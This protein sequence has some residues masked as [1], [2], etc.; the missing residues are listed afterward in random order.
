MLDI[1]NLMIKIKTR[2]R[3]SSQDTTYGVYLVFKF[4][5]SRKLSAKHMY[6][7]LKYTKGSETLHAYFAT[8]RDNDWMIPVLTLYWRASRHIIVE[9]VPSMLKALS[10]EQLMMQMKHEGIK[11]VLEVQQVLKSNLDE[12]VPQLSTNYEQTYKRSIDYEDGKVHFNF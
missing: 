12:Q 7:N 3:L 4:S 8:W 1:S 11:K 2:A 5:D 6:V 9:T 10:F